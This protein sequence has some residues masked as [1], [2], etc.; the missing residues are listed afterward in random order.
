MKMLNSGSAAQRLDFLVSMYAKAS[1]RDHV[2]YESLI[3]LFKEVIAVYSRLHSLEEEQINA[4]GYCAV[5]EEQDAVAPIED[6]DASFAPVKEKESESKNA[7]QRRMKKKESEEELEVEIIVPPKQ[8]Y[9]TDHF[10]MSVAVAKHV[11]EDVLPTESDQQSQLMAE[12]MEMREA[13]RNKSKQI[14]SFSNTIITSIVTAIC[15]DCNTDTLS[16]Q[17]LDTS[18]RNSIKVEIDSVL[19]WF[20]ANM[21]LA[22]E[23]LLS[24][25]RLNVSGKLE[26]NANELIKKNY[27]RVAPQPDGVGMEKSNLWTSA[28]IW[29]MHQYFRFKNIG[30]FK[31]LYSSKVHGRSLNRFIHHVIGYKAESLFTVTTTQGEVFGAFVSTPW[32]MS[33]TYWSNSDC[34][35]FG[36]TPILAVRR[37]NSPSTASMI[38]GGGSASANYVYFFANKKSFTGKP[39]GIGFGGTIGNPRIWIDEDL[40]QGTVRSIDPSF[41]NG[42][43]ASNAAFDIA[44]IE[45]WGSC[46]DYAEAQL[47]RERRLRDKDAERARKAG[48]KAGWNEGADKF[49]MDLMGKT[50]HSDGIVEANEKDRR[51]KKAREAQIAE[52]AAKLD[53][54]ERESSNK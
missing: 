48:D 52:A 54:M 31:L 8:K 29:T 4:L 42:Q 21:P 13:E 32:D 37:A 27:V 30:S 1:D 33:S 44:S 36:I 22:G 9:A 10:N 41:E 39:I 25:V 49:I 50:G 3:S 35:L 16:M 15:K 51:E 53:A 11:V 7:N 46:T 12:V 47:I 23:V 18:S 38:S 19:K 5:E 20:S 2:T 45:V 28:L 17:T 43:L 14:E 34:F 40:A 6:R 24:L 26:A